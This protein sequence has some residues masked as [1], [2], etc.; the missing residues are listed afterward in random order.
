MCVMKESNSVHSTV[1]KIKIGC[2]FI[3]FDSKNVIDFCS[4]H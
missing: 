3:S 1:F 2:K 4:M